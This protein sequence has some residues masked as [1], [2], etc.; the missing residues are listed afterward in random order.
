M[1]KAE[2]TRFASATSGMRHVFIRN[3]ELAAGA[4]ASRQVNISFQIPPIFRISCSSD[5]AWITDPAP[6]N[7]SAL[8]KA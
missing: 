5:I 6:R 1:S 8:K 7:R 2:I 3:L 4:G